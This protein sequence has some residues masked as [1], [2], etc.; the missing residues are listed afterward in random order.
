M[1]DTKPRHIG[2]SKYQ[3]GEPRVVEHVDRAEW[4]GVPSVVVGELWAGFLLGTGAD[5]NIR[6]LEDFLNRAV[7]E[8]LFA[9]EDV[10]HIYGEIFVDLRGKGR[11][12]PTNDIWIAATA[13][14][15]G[16]TVLTFDEH[17][18]EIARVGTLILDRHEQRR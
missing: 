13:A 2:Y 10:A 14:R 5:E 7:V 15:A 11:P 9:D 8:V 16:A 4:V 18:R 3:R 17:F 12:L 1:I 6:R